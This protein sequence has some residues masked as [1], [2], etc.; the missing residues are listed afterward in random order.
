MLLLLLVFYGG[1]KTLS[2][3][4]VVFLRPVFYALVFNLDTS[5][6]LRHTKT[7]QYIRPVL[8]FRAFCWALSCP[9][10]CS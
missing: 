2:R 8:V 5:F 1:L 3:V 6:F 10:S 9:C 7:R 4:N